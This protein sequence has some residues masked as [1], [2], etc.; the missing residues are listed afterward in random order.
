MGGHAHAH[1]AFLFQ[2]V[3][4][5]NQGNHLRSFKWSRL[6]TPSSMELKESAYEGRETR[7]VVLTVEP[8][9]VPS[10]ERFFLRED[11]ENQHEGGVV[12]LRHL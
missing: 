7:F 10:P 3:D 1:Q 11:Q 8:C 9:S 4:L 12:G 6:L 2:E 5:I